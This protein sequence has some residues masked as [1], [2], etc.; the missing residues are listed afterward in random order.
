M[1]AFN[2]SIPDN[3]I[4]FFQEFLDMIGARYEKTEDYDF[5]LSDEQKKILD[6]QEDLPL[7][8]YQDSDEF[9]EELKKEY[10]L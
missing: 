1:T 6:S 2:V 8:E 5:V 3:K 7:S 4:S 10:G 9:L